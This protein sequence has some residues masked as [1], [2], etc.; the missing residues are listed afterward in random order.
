MAGM[1][2][3]FRQYKYII[4]VRIWDHTG[5]QEMIARKTELFVYLFIY[6]FIIYVY[7]FTNFYVI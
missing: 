3:E 2:A 7:L 1:R 6:N 4:Y 5:Q